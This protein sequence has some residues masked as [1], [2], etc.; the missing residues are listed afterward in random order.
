MKI[1]LA[2]LNQNKLLELRKP[3]EALGIELISQKDCGVFTGAE[4]TGVTFEEN[5][6]QKAR[7]VMEATGLP[8]LAD[9]SGLS[10]DALNGAPGVHSHRFGNLDSDE[11]RCAYLLEMLRDVP[12][13]RRGAKFVCVITLLMPDGR[14]LAARGE[15]CGTILRA[16]RGKN[17]FGYDPLFYFPN[18]GKTFAELTK[19]E[20]SAVSHRGNALRN[21]AETYE[22][23]IGH[24]NE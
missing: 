19:E 20:K 1:V 23:M 24:L 2:S 10:V 5:S 13:D 21:F 4:E 12:D 8:A 22:E 16:C 14:K 6:E 11:A 18:L 7:Y 15:C 17:G 3:L 9:D